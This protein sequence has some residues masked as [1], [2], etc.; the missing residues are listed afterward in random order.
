MLHPIP[1]S[2]HLQY[3]EVAIAD[4]THFHIAVLTTIQRVKKKV[5]SVEIPV[6]TRRYQSQGWLIFKGQLLASFDNLVLGDINSNHELFVPIRRLAPAI[7]ISFEVSGSHPL[8]SQVSGCASLSCNIPEA[9]FPY[10]SLFHQLAP[11]F[12]AVYPFTQGDSLV[13][14]AKQMEI[15]KLNFIQQ[16]IHRLKQVPFYQKSFNL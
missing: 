2:P 14:K 16:N 8:P 12:V 6:P 9:E 4:L 15:H 11:R 5:F 10:L 1:R 13:A 7:P 3:S